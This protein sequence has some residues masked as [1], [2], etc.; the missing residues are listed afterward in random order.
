M[1]VRQ[2]YYRQKIMP[3]AGW[4]APPRANIRRLLYWTIR[5]RSYRCLSD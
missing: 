2:M 4:E 3:V 1:S 5:P